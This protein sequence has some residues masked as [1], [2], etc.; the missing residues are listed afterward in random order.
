M[1]VRLLP[2]ILLAGV[3]TGCLILPIPTAKHT[4]SDARTRGEIEKRALRP[5]RAGATSLEDVLLRFG[6][7]D[8]VGLDGRWLLYRWLTVNG[9]LLLAAGNSGDAVRM[10]SDR[11][12]L[13]F[14][15][16]ASGLLVRFGELETLVAQGLGDD[17]TVDS[18][19]PLEV[20][21]LY[22]PGL[23]RDR[24]ARL[25]LTPR[26]LTIESDSAKIPILTLPADRIRRLDHD[27]DDDEPVWY[28]G[29]LAYHLDYVDEKGV[30]HDLHLQIDA[31]S[32]PRLAR[33]LREYCAEIK[34][35]D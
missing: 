15:F 33:Y 5:L 10:G 14:E 19:S 9:Y 35:T 34:I 6:E 13:L 16:D 29:W 28:A 11:H 2:L 8:A 25:L 1:T 31:L 30:K 22:G 4:P 3:A 27:A 21:V 12:D 17:L 24:G 26:T 23:K 32:L 18:S 7:P 20:E